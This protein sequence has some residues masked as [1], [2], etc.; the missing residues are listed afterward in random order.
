MAG[1]QGRMLEV[2][3]SKGTIGNS[4]VDKKILRDYIGG[5]GLAAK[6]M[7]DRVST[8][9]D[10]LSPDNTMF[11]TTG[12]T[13]GT[14]LPG[15]AR[16][17]VCAKSPLTDMWGE[18]NC[19]GNFAAG[20]KAAG[21]DGIVF[22]GASSKPV[23][24][25]IEDGKAEIRD[26]SDLWGKNTHEITDILKERHGGNKARVIS[27]G[28]AGENLVKF[29]A[30]ANEKKDFAARCGI[31]AVMG[32]KKLKAVVVKGSGKAQLADPDK[33]GERRKILI[34]KVKD[35]I[36][37]QVLSMMGTNAATGVSA[38]TGDL[39]GKNWT[40]G[41]NQAISAKIDG[42]V[43]SGPV[44]YLGNDSCFGCT[45][46]C[47]RRVHIPEGPY[48][49]GERPGPEYEGVASLGSLLMIGDMAAV[50]KMNEL[51][52]DW[53]VDVISCG[54][55]VA[56]AMDLWEKGLITA[57]DTNG[58]DLTWGNADAVVKLIP[59]IAKRE[60]LGALLAEGSK[61]AS[62]KFGKGAAEFAVQIKGMEVPMHDPRANYAAGLSYATGIRGACHTSDPTYSMSAGIVNWPEFN[63]IPGTDLKSNTGLGNLVKGA[64]DYGSIYNSAIICY[65]VSYVIDAEDLVE[66]MRASS[67]FDYTF[68]ELAKCGERIWHLK[69]GLNNLMGV[70]ASDDTLPKRILTPTTEGGAAGS[71]PDI[72]MLLK[73]YYPIRGLAED[74]RPTKAV[75]N[76]LGLQDM[77]AKLY[78]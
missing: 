10:P 52:N 20:L 46:G 61:R 77:A 32:S 2:N 65:M 5:S 73:E 22:E 51:C 27:I 8:N 41:D 72:E 57:K 16:F 1:F 25:L 21:L 60:G 19:G 74:G 58:L 44:Y 26:A 4:T 78:K 50:I 24:L 48:A 23:Y 64:Q 47:K 69:R 75:L 9:V 39:P 49:G 54:A 11:L 33:F 68:E 76:S 15:G 70:K 36:A 42:S 67:G 53:G 38:I 13:S 55:T 31:G 37:T 66:L 14:S 45:V 63:M 34:Q 30:I 59:M 7:F 35:H 29:A 17:A 28:Q 56:M 12:P 62:A 3:L 43:L 71:A 6:L 18:A 40:V